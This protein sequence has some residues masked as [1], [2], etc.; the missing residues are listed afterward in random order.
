MLKL[1]AVVLG[2]RAQGCSIE[3]HDVVFTVAHSIEDAFP[4]LVNKWFGTSKRLHIDSIIELTSVDGHQ[5][6]ITK[7]KSTSSEKLFMVN[8]GGYKKDYF[9][10]IHEFKFFVGANKNE[11]L[12]RAKKVLAL[13][14]SESHCDDNI[15]IDEVLS[16][17]V[18]DDYHLQLIPGGESSELKIQ[19][20]YLRLDVP[21]I[22]AQA[23]ALRDPISI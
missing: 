10:E 15:D 20:K 7:E 18:V 8:F 3:L 22:I 19:S 6:Q 11:V 13:E 16:L 9:G 14:L 23:Q 2:G 1:F 4:V 5:V 12:T 21:E 17:E